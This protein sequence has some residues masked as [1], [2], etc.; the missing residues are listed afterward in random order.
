MSKTCDIFYEIPRL[1]ACLYIYPSHFF[2]IST[3]RWRQAH[4]HPPFHLFTLAEYLI[5]WDN[6]KSRYYTIVPIRSSSRYD[7]FSSLQLIHVLFMHLCQRKSLI[8]W[9][10]STLYFYHRSQ[11]QNSL[12]LHRRLIER[13]KG[14][15]ILRW[16][17]YDKRHLLCA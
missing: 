9:F 13:E 15:K 1:L 14:E 4:F 17:H 16:M 7:S 3:Y 11:T 8:C 12:L 6:E 10:L 2:G 5:E